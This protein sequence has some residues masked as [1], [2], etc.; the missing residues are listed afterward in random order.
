MKSEKYR[1]ENRN[2]EKEREVMDPENEGLIETIRQVC[3]FWRRRVKWTDKKNR[4]IYQQETT[5]NLCRLYLVAD[6]VDE[7]QLKPRSSYKRRQC[8][9]EFQRG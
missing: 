8:S 2:S 7:E 1:A 5:S 6:E 3:D 4:Y 9:Q